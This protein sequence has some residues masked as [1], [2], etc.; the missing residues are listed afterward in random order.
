MPLNY[1]QMHTNCKYGKCRDQA[2]A[3]IAPAIGEDCV[4]QNAWLLCQF[5]LLTQAKSK[6]YRLYSSNKVRAVLRLIDAD[7]RIRKA[8]NVSGSVFPWLTRR[9]YEFK[10]DV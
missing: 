10:E 6:A 1:R 7:T 9:L 2:F 3:V 4:V 5:Q 8:V